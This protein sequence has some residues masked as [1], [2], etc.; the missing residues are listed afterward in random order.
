MVVKFFKCPVCGNVIEKIVD[1][2]VPVRDCLL[3]REG[4]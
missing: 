2:G 4:L 1:A 3:V